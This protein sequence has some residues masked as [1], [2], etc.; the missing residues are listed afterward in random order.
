MSKPLHQAPLAQTDIGQGYEEWLREA[1]DALLLTLI[2]E[3]RARPADGQPHDVLETIVHARD[4][5]GQWLS[6]ASL[7][8]HVNVLLVA[9]HETTTTRSAWT[10]YLLATLPQ[11]RARILAELAEQVCDAPLSVEAAR[12]LHAL[13]NIIKEVGRLPTAAAPLSSARHPGR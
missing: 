12:N 2:A 11:Q 10:L 4:E 6:D 5:H 9:G 7:L 13:D 3:R 1:L 8:G